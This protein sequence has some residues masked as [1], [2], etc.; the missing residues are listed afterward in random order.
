MMTGD[1]NYNVPPSA[2]QNS[3]ARFPARR[4]LLRAAFVASVGLSLPRMALAK[5]DRPASEEPPEPGDLFVFPLGDHAGETIAPRDIPLGGPQIS[6]WPMDPKTKVVRKGSPLNQ[7]LLLRLD[8][9]ELDEDTAARS[10]GG[11]LAYSALCTHAGCPVIGW[12]KDQGIMVLKCFCHQ[13]EFDPQ[14]GAAV[15]FGP[16]PRHLAALPVEIVAGTL[17]VA[18]KFIG[19]AMPEIGGGYLPDVE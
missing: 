17:I 8:P 16:A 10:A 9:Q 5:G 13:S 18:G 2:R 19:S 7:V 4:G 3:R 12:V 6:A 11:I 15:V 14:H 1:R